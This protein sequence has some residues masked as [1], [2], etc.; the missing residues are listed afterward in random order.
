[1]HLSLN[2]LSN[3][4]EYISRVTNIGFFFF[5]FFYHCLEQWFSGKLSRRIS[6]LFRWK[7]GFRRRRFSRA[8]RPRPTVKVSSTIYRLRALGTVAVVFQTK[9][10]T[11][12]LFAFCAFPSAGSDVNPAAFHSGEPTESLEQNTDRTKRR[13]YLRRTLAGIGKQNF[14]TA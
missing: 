12:W 3:D 8:C 7:S 10:R 14:G 1:M 9:P 5:V 6:A 2:R 13:I 11:G 4:F